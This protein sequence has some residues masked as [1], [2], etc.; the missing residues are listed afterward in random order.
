[1]GGNRVYEF[2]YPKQ[3]IH[4]I[5]DHLTE[6]LK[7]ESQTTTP[8]P[9]S[10]PKTTTATS[11]AAEICGSLGEDPILPTILHSKPNFK[12]NIVHCPD[13]I[14]ASHPQ[15][16][17]VSEEQLIMEAILHYPIV[18]ICG[19]T[20]G[21]KMTQVPQILFKAGWESSSPGDVGMI[22]IT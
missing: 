11:T 12:P 21:G 7:L 19:E 22:G 2:L 16:P 15:L 10:S 4:N 6:F 14:Q 1:M 18:V 20:E 8:F 9:R 13:T 3:W 17:I 5:H